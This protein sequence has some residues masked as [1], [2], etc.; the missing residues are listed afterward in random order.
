MKTKTYELKH[1]IEFG[2]ETILELE[3]QRVKA[4]HLRGL[5]LNPG[6]E[7]ML[8][9]LKE[10]TGRPKTVIDELDIE[11]VQPLMDLLGDMMGNS[12]PSGEVT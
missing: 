12:H 5:P 11:D 3:I 10:V 9:L 1:P 2:K 6:F 8:N 4:K 7:D